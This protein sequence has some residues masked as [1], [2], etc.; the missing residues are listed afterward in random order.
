[1]SGY[2]SRGYGALGREGGAPGAQDGVGLPVS[3]GVS[4]GELNRRAAGF[5]LDSGPIGGGGALRGRGGLPTMQR[6]R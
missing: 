3:P 5:S 1:V 2:I 6:D 4:P